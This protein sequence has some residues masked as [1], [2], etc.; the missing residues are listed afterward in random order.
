MASGIGDKAEMSKLT[1]IQD[2]STDIDPVWAGGGA[3]IPD[4]FSWAMSVPREEGF[5][6]VDGARVHYLRWGRRGRAKLL[7][8]HGFLAHARCFAFIAPYLAQD[9]D[10]VAFDLAGMGDSEM[11]GVADEAARGKEFAEISEALDLRADGANPVII[12]HSFGARAALTAV[13]QT[14]DA[15]AGVIVCDLMVMRPQK[16]EEYWTMGLWSPGSGNPD[17]PVRR[18]PSYAAARERYILAPPQPVGEPFLLDYM[19]FHSLRRDGEEWA[20][21]FSPEVFRRDN[22]SDEWLSVGRKLVDAPGRKA[23]IHGE[24]SQLFDRDSACYI[25]ELGGGDIPIVAVP[26]ARHHLM[27]DQPLAFVAALR[28]VLAFWN[29]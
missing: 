15:F 10:V 8:S 25:R 1:A 21:K 18:Y 5:V 13:S 29:I 12:A 16:L 20:W 22:N 28:A 2:G 6:E 17:K 24:K 19:A 26:N 7:M 9:Y 27:L 14:P 4:W 3:H 23:V 11:R